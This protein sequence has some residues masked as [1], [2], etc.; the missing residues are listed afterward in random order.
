MSRLVFVRHVRVVL[1]SSPI[2]YSARDLSRSRSYGMA[3]AKGKAPQPWADRP[4]KL[5]VTPTYTTK[6]VSHP[7]ESRPGDSTLPD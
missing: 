3:D 5:I 6:K 2:N 4:M 1:S 7:T